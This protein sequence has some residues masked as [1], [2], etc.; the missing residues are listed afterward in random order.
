MTVILFAIFFISKNTA[1]AADLV[2][3]AVPFTPEAPDGLMVKPWNNACEEATLAMLDEYYS[4][5]KNPTIPK[6][7][8]KKTILK[9]INIEN[10]IFGY[11][12]NTNAQEMTKLVNGYSKYFEAQIVRNPTLEQIKNELDAGRPTIALVYGFELN[13]P[14][15][16]F[17]RGGSYY[18]TFVIKGFD[19][20]TKEFIVNDNGDFKKGLD[21]RYKYDTILGALR[22]YNHKTQK[23][24]KPATALFT[25]QRMLAKTKDSNKVYLIKNDKKYHITSPLIFKNRGWKWNLVITASKEWLNKFEDGPAM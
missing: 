22:D 16:I 14:R 4:G 2:N 24:E 6:A 3:L 20:N 23:T 12:G 10:K 15:I 9:Y 17:S 5:N 13:N 8:A 1:R 21:L 25:S 19:D 18:H 7:A 11:N